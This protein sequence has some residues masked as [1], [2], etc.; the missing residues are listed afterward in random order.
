MHGAVGNAPGKR[1]I[2]GFPNPTNEVASRLVAGM[3]VLMCAATI[4]TREAWLLIPI[5]YGFWARLIGGPKLSPASA[6]ASK[7]LAPRFFAPK[8][9]AG[10]PKRF[11]QGIGAAI[12]SVAV[13]CW[14]VPGIRVV[15]W[16]AL[17][18]LG[19]AAFL[20]AAGGFCLGC[21]AF[22]LLIKIGVVP[23]EVCA[24]CADISRRFPKSEGGG[25]LQR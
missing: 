22:A 11:A 3:V 2:V 12:S 1:G 19:F 9:V 17:G 10:P 23:E 18:I 14:F 21:K 15:T 6:I 7:V 8:L 16:W 20:E 24:D 13:A 25:S 5:V 4:V